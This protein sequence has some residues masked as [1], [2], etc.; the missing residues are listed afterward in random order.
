MNARFQHRRPE[1]SVVL[2]TWN[3]SAML[4]VCLREMFSSLAEDVVREV[5]LM[6]NCSDDAT[7]AILKHYSTMPDVKV[8]RNGKNMRLNAYR[9]LFRMARGRIIIE[10]D[11]DVLR[12]PQNFDRT[13]LDYMEA[14]PDYG[15]LALNVEQNEKTNGAKPKQ[16]CYRDDIRGDKI[17]EEG[18]VGGWCSAFYRWHWL[19]ASPLLSLS[20]GLSMSRCE[21]GFL[22][23]I[24]EKIFHKRHG[25][26]KNAVCLH[27]CG[28]AYSRDFGLLKTAREK[29][30]A[31]GMRD[32]AAKYD[33]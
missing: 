7:S 22:M 8:V 26:I 24:A 6:D 17:V 13:L 11:D 5:I 15:Y 21:D 4:E 33:E 16:S 12:F 30:L 19:L 14:Y 2:L 23:G 3:R 28:P 29:Y 10:V 20:G 9:K 31:A 27:A 18:P 1:V 32:M 25:L